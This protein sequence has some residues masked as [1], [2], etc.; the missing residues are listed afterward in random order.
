VRRIRFDARAN[1]ERGRVE[2]NEILI[3]RAAHRAKNLQVV[4]RFEEICLPLAILADGDEAVARNI[5]HDVREIAEVAH[6]EMRQPCGG[7]T[8]VTHVRVTYR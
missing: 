7:L 4:N 8:R 6:V 5:K 3:A 1:V 2:T